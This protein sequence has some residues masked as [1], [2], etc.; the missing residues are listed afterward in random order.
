[1]WT[2]LDA[3]DGQNIPKRSNRQL[4]RHAK[5]KTEPD[6]TEIVEKSKRQSFLSV[7]DSQIGLG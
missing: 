1:M 3:E 4:I 6:R 5:A 2:A 7:L